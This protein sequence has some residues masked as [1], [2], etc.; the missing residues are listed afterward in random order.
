[1]VP[2]KDMDQ[3]KLENQR[4]YPNN[5]LNMWYVGAQ[6]RFGKSLLLTLKGS[7]SQ[8][9]GTPGADFDPVRGQF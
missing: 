8:N 6:G 2:G 1:M 4:F 5:R 7:Y 9:F 3:S